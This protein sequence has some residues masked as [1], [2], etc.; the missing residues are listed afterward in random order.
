VRLAQLNTRVGEVVVGLILIAI[1]L[2]ALAE[3]LR[4]GAGWGTSGP[5]AGFFPFWAA[6]VVIVSVAVAIVQA[7]RAGSARPLYE[8]PDEVR[9]LL[10][11]GLPI[12]AA[13]ASL[14]YLGFYLMSAIYMGF[15]GLWYGRYRWYVVLPIAVLLPV[16]LF[17]VFERGFRIGLPK[18]FL[19]GDL[20]PF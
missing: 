6:L 20:I 12:V 8:S 16:V 4:L 17:F 14:P 18:S 9:E 1:A 19:Y 15:F 5:Q 10:K 3:S 2:I 7:L 13:V 11:V